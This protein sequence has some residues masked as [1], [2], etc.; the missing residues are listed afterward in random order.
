[1]TAPTQP[2][3]PSI[4]TRP[5]RVNRLL[6]RLAGRLDDD[7]LAVL[8]TAVADAEDEFDTERIID[9]FLGVLLTGTLRVTWDEFALV[10]EEIGMVLEQFLDQG[11]LEEPPALAHSFSSP[12]GLSSAPAAAILIG[13]DVGSL[14]GVWLAHRSDAGNPEPVPVWLVETYR[15]ADLVELTAD[16]QQRLAEAGEIP[17]RVEVFEEGDDLP[18]YHRAALEVAT[19]QWTDPN[20]PQPRLAQVF[21][22]VDPLSGPYFGDG[23]PVI[24]E[25]LRKRLL[26]YLAS[27]EVLLGDLGTLDDVVEP[28]AVGAV[29]AGF[30][31]DGAWVW[32]DAVVYYLERHGLAPDPE[33]IQ[34]V[35]A[36]KGPPP[37]PGLVAAGLALTALMDDEDD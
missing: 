22:G 37:R 13:D 7:E 32:P 10:I 17:P 35:L 6:F 14:T 26:D 34:H 33:L 15:G 21:D 18:P 23:H 29:S 11:L 2:P 20:M 4:L 5:F 25:F 31:T 8:R 12:P 36:T 3:L 1:V 9:H 30:R 27:A 28:T 24:A 19:Q 16:L